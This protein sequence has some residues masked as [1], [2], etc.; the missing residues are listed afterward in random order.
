MSTTEDGTTQDRPWYETYYAEIE[1]KDISILER[2]HTE[3]TVLQLG[4]HAPVHGRDGAR[5]VMEHFWPTI[6]RMHHH[7]TKVITEGDDVVLEADVTYTRLD[8]SEVTVASA[9]TCELRDGLIAAQRIYVDMAPLME[10]MAVP[11]SLE[12]A[13]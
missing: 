12:G 9:T 4:N 11:P 8:G 7:F 10:G 3:D 2:W 5:A 1:A 6:E 13:T